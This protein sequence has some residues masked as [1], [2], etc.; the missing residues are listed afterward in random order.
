MKILFISPCN[1][2]GA[3]EEK[4]IA[5][6][7]ER[8]YQTHIFAYHYARLKDY[9]ASLP[10]VTV[11]FVPLRVAGKVQRAM[12]FHLLPRLKRTIRE[13]KPDVI[14]SGNCWNDSFLAALSGFHPLLVVPYGSDVMLDPERSR[15]LDLFNRVAFRG[16]DWVTVDA[17]WV[18]KTI[19]R[20]YRYPED[21]ITVIPRGVDVES[22]AQ[23]RSPWRDSLRKEL[24]WDAHF[25]VMMNR[26][27]EDVYGIDVF[28]KAMTTV[29]KENPNVRVMFIGAGSLTPTY[30]EYIREHNLAPSFYTPGKIP[31][32]LL[33]KY[34]HAADV[35]VSSSRSD[36]TS[37]S[38]LEAMSARLGVV[39]TDVPS[40]KEWVVQG[41]NGE[42]VPRGDSDALAAAI[43]RTSRN[44]GQVR[45]YGE[46]NLAVV[47]SR[48]DWNQNFS[49]FEGLY[50][51]LV[52]GEPCSK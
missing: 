44:P 14:H 8:G 23:L 38:L 39:V 13:F 46:R 28:L 24:G 22:I 16:A 1:G 29:I 33:H 27:H 18:K 45:A 12:S 51:Q 3:H 41:E 26:H 25:V 42:V 31:R 40:I 32:D 11:E 6:L 7:S 47:R 15:L 5:A 4:F 34:L 21:K 43:L 35:Y 30:M 52:R 10:G 9:F 49:A 36:G 19:I 17:G 20:R 37:V 2:I 50:R 48:A